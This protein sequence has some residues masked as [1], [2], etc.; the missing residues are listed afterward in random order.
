M[1]QTMRWALVHPSV[2]TRCWRQTTQHCFAHRHHCTATGESRTTTILKSW[3]KLSLGCK[4]KFLD[5][6]SWFSACTSLLGTKSFTDQAV[7]EF[8]TED[9]LLKELIIDQENGL[10]HHNPIKLWYC[11]IS[12]LIFLVTV[13]KGV[14]KQGQQHSSKG[15]STQARATA[16]KQGQQHKQGR[17]ELVL[18]FSLWSDSILANHMFNTFHTVVTYLLNTTSPTDFLHT[19][20]PDTI[21]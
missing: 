12:F 9:S 6:V 11:S 8:G 3:R 21:H 13:C 1:A 4:L 2:C 15:N 16:L 5:F 18:I 14:N 10:R 19:I 20:H 7:E 17:H